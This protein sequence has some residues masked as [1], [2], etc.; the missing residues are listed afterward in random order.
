MIKPLKPDEY[1]NLLRRDFH[2]FV[3]RVFFQ[4]NPQADY[5]A[6]WHI[7]MMCAELHA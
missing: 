1:R 7:E 2:A 4:L 3:S 6:N 5:L